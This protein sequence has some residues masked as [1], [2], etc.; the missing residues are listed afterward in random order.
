MLASTIVSI[1]S[2]I[3]DSDFHSDKCS[4][5]IS[6]AS[7]SQH[8]FDL[9]NSLGKVSKIILLIQCLTLSR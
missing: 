3:P 8:G 1:Y 4:S 9:Q 2:A 5:A 6:I 7:A